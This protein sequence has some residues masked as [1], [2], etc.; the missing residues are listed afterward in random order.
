MQPPAVCVAALGQ[1]VVNQFASVHVTL[2][3]TVEND[4]SGLQYH[5]LVRSWAVQLTNG[6][7]QESLTDKCAADCRVSCLPQS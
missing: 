4:G 3:W 2:K 1:R 6:E 5:W 7:A